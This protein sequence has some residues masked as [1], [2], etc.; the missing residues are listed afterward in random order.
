RGEAFAQLIKEYGVMVRYHSILN[1]PHVLISDPKL[2][3]QILITR[4]YDFPNF[5]LSRNLAKDLISE[6][7]SFAE[8]DDHKR[9]RKALSPSFSFANVK[10]MVP[11]FF[12]A[13]HQMK[14]IWLKQIGNKNEERITITELIPKIILDVIGLVG[15]N[16]EFNATTSHSELARAYHSVVNNM[17]HVLYVFL[18]D[19]LPSVRRILPAFYKDQYW[20]SVQLIH[21]IANKLVTRLINSNVWGNDLM[22]VLIQTNENLP[23]SE[24]LTFDEIRSQVTII[25]TA[26]HETTSVTLSWALYYLA[27]NSKAQDRLRKEI[28]DVFTDRNYFPTI[29]EIDHLEYLECVFK[30]TLRLAPP[31]PELMRSTVKDEIMNGYVIPKDTPLAI[32]IYAIQRDPLIW[33]DDA[34]N[35]NPSRWLDPEI[36]SKISTSHYFPFSAGRRACPGNKLA[37]LE[38]KMILPIIIRNFKFRIVEGF[39]FENRT[40]GLSKPVPGIDLLVSK[41]DSGSGWRSTCDTRVRSNTTQIQNQSLNGRRRLR[42]RKTWSEFRAGDTCD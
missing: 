29:E 35:F 32:P 14:D 28:L 17:P 21:G 23:A 2:I 1:Q 31:L 39:T 36:K 8:G 41:V 19:Y 27:K 4:S 11:T 18:A 33:G 5:F 37:L 25:L 16:Y 15:F 20:N 7:V 9:Q 22:S 6:S 24:Q 30:E 34:E 40:Q 3:Q 12:K 10:E 38:L 26:G 42:R 13:A